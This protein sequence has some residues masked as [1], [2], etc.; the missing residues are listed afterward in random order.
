[1]AIIG[2]KRKAEIMRDLGTHHFEGF[3]SSNTETRVAQERIL[4]E[5]AN[6]NAV[7]GYN[8]Q[9]KN[10]PEQLGQ[11]VATR[12]LLPLPEGKGEHLPVL[13]DE[14][15]LLLSKG[16]ITRRLQSKGP[17]QNAHRYALRQENIKQIRDYFGMNKKFD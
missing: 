17:L 1:M 15:E 8:R 5:L 14:A 7:I 3:L 9:A 10:L 2:N 12:E 4:K 13:H 11:P 6:G 16:I